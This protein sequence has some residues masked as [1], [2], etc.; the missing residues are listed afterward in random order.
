MGAVS[1]DQRLAP[2]TRRRS[3]CPSFMLRASPA[4]DLADAVSSRN[5]RLRVSS[6]RAPSP[7]L[8][9]VRVSQM[10]V[11]GFPASRHPRTSARVPGLSPAAPPFGA[12]FHASCMRA[13]CSAPRRAGK[14]GGSA[15]PRRHRRPGEKYGDTARATGQFIG[16]PAG[17]GDGASAPTTGATRRERLLR[18]KRRVLL[19][20]V[21]VALF[22]LDQ[23]MHVPAVLGLYLNRA[24]QSVVAFSSSSTARANW[25]HLLRQH[26]SSSTCSRNIV[27][28]EE[29]AFGVWFSLPVHRRRRSFAAPHRPEHQPRPRRDGRRRRFLPRRVGCGFIASGSSPSPCRTLAAD[30]GAQA[31]G[32]GRPAAVPWSGFSRPGGRWPPPRGIG[33][34]AMG[35]SNQVAHLAGSPLGRPLIPSSARSRQRPG[36]KTLLPRRASPCVTGTKKRGRRA[37]PK[38]FSCDELRSMYRARA[39]D[40][41]LRF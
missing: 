5:A 18:R 36:F 35:A 19:L 10:R 31:P 33:I 21:N 22:V 28:Q 14:P 17:L 2:S 38:G 34:G 6:P 11:V 23:W 26:A 29:G 1:I 32:G 24:V 25:A 4:R 39:A 15:S 8:A 30:G 13:A 40:P 37:K 3:G 9:R 41:R 16:V 27:E 20:L 7:A 12:R